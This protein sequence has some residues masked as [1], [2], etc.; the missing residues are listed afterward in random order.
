MPL[1][2]FAVQSTVPGAA[3][4]AGS[5]SSSA[6]A[7][8]RTRRRAKFPGISACSE[9]GI[10]ALRGLTRRGA[11]RTG[12]PATA[13]R[14]AAGYPVPSIGTAAAGGSAA[15]CAVYPRIQLPWRM[16]VSRIPLWLV[17]PLYQPVL[18]AGPTIDPRVAR[19]APFQPMRIVASS[20]GSTIESC[21]PYVAIPDRLR[22]D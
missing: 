16:A 13:P 19:L 7:V 12:P 1:R 17:M 21:C 18:E 10:C 22:P 9:Q 4:L 2:P 6:L 15:V 8:D 11:S 20:K 3:A 14:P 5:G